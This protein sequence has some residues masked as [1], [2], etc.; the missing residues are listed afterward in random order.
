M[1]SSEK[2]IMPRAKIR[3]YLLKPH[4]NHSQEFFDVGYTPFDTEKLNH[5]INALFDESK[6][7]DFRFIGAEKVKF[8]IF[9]ELGVTTK[10]RFRTVWQKDTRYAK[11][12]FITAH[13]E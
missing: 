3:D 1:L 2:Y 6:A 9:M 12:R 8:S 7:T 4:T 5:D 13:R 10:K 11:P